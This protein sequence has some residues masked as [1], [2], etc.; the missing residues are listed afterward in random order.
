MFCFS[1]SLNDENSKIEFVR[2]PSLLLL[3]FA[4]GIAINFQNCVL[5]SQDWI[6]NY[7]FTNLI[8][9]FELPL[10]RLLFFTKHFIN[11]EFS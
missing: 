4:S 1:V 9:Q 2:A 5:H 8:V 7:V 3:F 11:S 6:S 10:I